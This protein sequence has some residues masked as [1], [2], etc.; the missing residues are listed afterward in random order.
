MLHCPAIWPAVLLLFNEGSLYV[1]ILALHHRLG[2]S[3]LRSQFNSL[4]SRT[5]LERPGF[6]W[7]V[8]W[9]QYVSVPLLLLLL[10]QPKFLNNDA[11]CTNSIVANTTSLKSRP[12]WTAMSGGMEC[13]ALAFGP[14]ISGAVA[15]YSQWRVSFYIITPVGVAV[16]LSVFF[17]VHNIQRPEH[18][19]LSN[20]EKLKRL[21]MPGFAAFVPLAICVIL[22]L[23]WGGSEFTW[24]NW[25]II[26]LWALAGILLVV[27]LG[28][29]LRSGDE[30]MFPLRLLCQR[31]VAFGALF[32]FCNSA[33]LFVIAYYVSVV[34]F[35]QPKPSTS[36]RPVRYWPRRTW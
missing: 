31:T 10:H 9:K 26:L 18:A 8:C 35:L 36:A 12:T 4:Y 32:T 33:A 14:L 13:I 23:E 5:C 27:F 30:G 1:V 20:R 2:G 15:R 21:D 29:E 6:G 34:D 25:R 19:E 22:A 24:S 17:F 16:I 11:L 7:R 28:M 3:R